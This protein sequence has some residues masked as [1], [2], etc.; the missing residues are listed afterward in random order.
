MSFARYSVGLGIVGLVSMST[1]SCAEYKKSAEKSARPGT[2]SHAM[3]KSRSMGLAMRR[4]GGEEKAS[5]DEG[6]EA[7]PAVNSAGLKRQIIYNASVDLVVE[8]FDDVPRQVAALAQRFDA[9]VADSTISGETGSHRSG[10]WRLRVPVDRF[11]E[12]LDAA[13]K[14]GEVRS[15]SSESEDVS[16]EYY[17]VEARIANYKK[18]ESRLIELLSDRTGKLEDVLAVEREIARVRGEIERAE[19]RMRVLNDLT[20][21]STVTLT[22]EEI[23]NYVPEETASF[24]T[25]IRRTFQRSLSGLEIFG[26]GLVIF[27]VA[28]GPWLLALGVP[29]L[30]VLLAIRR[31]WR[32]AVRASKVAPP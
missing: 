27:S 13:T 17:D 7:K 2:A 5:G 9:V 20:T 29:L 1:I 19:G 26:K 24:G 32:R 18:E 10:R 15:R 16:E 11:D 14:L 3:D 31:S 12:M 8:N 22:V 4:G 6:D 23:K 30:V 28:A 25:Q 21:L